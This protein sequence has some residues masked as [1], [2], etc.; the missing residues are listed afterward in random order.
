VVLLLVYGDQVL[1]PVVAIL[2]QKR[3][4]GDF[5]AELAGSGLARNFEFHLFSL[6]FFQDAELRVGLEDAFL[7]VGCGFEGDGDG[8]VLE[9]FVGGVGEVGFEV[10]E[11]GFV[12]CEVVE[13][14]AVGGLGHA[15]EVVGLDDGFLLHWSLFLLL[16]Q[17]LLPAGGGWECQEGQQEHN[18]DHCFAHLILI[19]FESINYCVALYYRLSVIYLYKGFGLRVRQFCFSWACV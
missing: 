9:G 5:P 13:L 4:L 7:G 19:I 12:L 18:E 3:G 8:V 17:L 6:Y 15:G 11:D 14:V 10:E 1:E 16:E 2:L